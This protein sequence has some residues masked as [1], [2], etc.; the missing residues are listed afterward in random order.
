MG[1][2]TVVLPGTCGATTGCSFLSP[3]F[4]TGL[5]LGGK[6]A[7]QR[8]TLDC[9]GEALKEF[10]G[11]VAA[12]ELYDGPFCVLSLVDNRQ[13]RRL[14]YEVLEEK[15]SQKHIEGFFA[16]FKALLDTHA[17][18]VRGITTDGSDLYPGPILKVF[19]EVPHQVCRFHMVADITW[20]VLHA[21]AQVRKALRAQLPKLSRGRPSRR[22]ARL[23]RRN[24]RMREHISELFEHRYLFVQHSLSGAEHKTVVRLTRRHLQLHHLREIMEEVYRLFDRRCRTETA[25]AKLSGLRQRV[26]R[27]RRL[28]KALTILFN[29]NL[30]KA[31]LFLDD[32]LL[33][34]TSNAVERGNRRY[35]KMQQSVYHVRTQE[36]LSERLA[37]DLLREA[38]A[39]GRHTTDQA[40]HSSRNR[41]QITL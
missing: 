32:R 41:R 14:V 20:A 9:L 38:H 8:L 4:K 1:C 22:Q 39:T 40:L 3:P 5:R 21:L 10:S 29:P 27:F 28:R 15:P 26:R 12:D 31:L 11:Y 17:L 24:Q 36:H 34:A 33:P 30:E 18:V 37:L 35:R 13:G 7:T 19:G 23:A 16:R 6:R 25:L 2:L